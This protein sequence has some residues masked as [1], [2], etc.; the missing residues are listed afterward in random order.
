MSHLRMSDGTKVPLWMAGV[1]ALVGLVIGFG[2]LILLG[3]D[4]APWLAALILILLV[5]A[6]YEL[7]R[8]VRRPRRR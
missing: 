5:G 6:V 2:G 7:V 1:A 8:R 4:R 3:R